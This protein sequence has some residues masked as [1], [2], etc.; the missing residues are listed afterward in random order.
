MLSIRFGDLV[1]C[2]TLIEFFLRDW[3]IYVR[4]IVL[5]EMFFII[6]L[7]WFVNIVV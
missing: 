5:T 6:Q 4:A 1:F 3:I 2:M 7:N